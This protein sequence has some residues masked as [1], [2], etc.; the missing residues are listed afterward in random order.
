[1]A[2]RRKG[3]HRGLLPA[4]RQAAGDGDDLLA[5]D[6]A[7]AGGVLWDSADSDGDLA[8]EGDFRR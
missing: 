6:Y 2:G 3:Q 4:R 7:Q 5:V 1:M 8:V